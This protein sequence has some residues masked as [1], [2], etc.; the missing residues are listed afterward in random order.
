[1]LSPN[2]SPSPPTSQS[3]EG[4]F[5]RVRPAKALSICTTASRAGARKEWTWRSGNVARI[6]RFFIK[7]LNAPLSCLSLSHFHTFFL[8]FL[9]SSSLRSR[10]PSLLPYF[11]LAS[12]TPFHTPSSPPFKLLANHSGYPLRGPIELLFVP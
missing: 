1:M 7:C 2:K 12:L 11:D 4:P 9:L 6:W 10:T 5:S 3:R 8:F